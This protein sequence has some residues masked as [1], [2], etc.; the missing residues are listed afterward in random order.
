MTLKIDVTVVSSKGG[1]PGAGRKEL[2]NAKRKTRRADLRDWGGDCQNGWGGAG[3][4]A[5]DSGGRPSAVCH[6]GK[7]SGAKNAGILGEEGG[8]GKGTGNKAGIG[9]ER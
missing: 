9:V 2:E 6:S 5:Q 4:A 1:D 7:G 8:G 3:I